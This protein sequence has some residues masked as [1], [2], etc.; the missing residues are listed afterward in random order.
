MVPVSNADTLH[1]LPARWPVLTDFGSS[2]SFSQVNSDLEELSI[3]IREE[4]DGFLGHPSP[5]YVQ[6]IAVNPAP[7]DPNG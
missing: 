2:N 5:L 1:I 6:D 3:W 4:K 7:P